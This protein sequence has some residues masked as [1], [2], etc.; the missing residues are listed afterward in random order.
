MKAARRNRVTHPVRR[1]RRV[2]RNFQKVQR[3]LESGA[4]HTLPFTDNAETRKGDLFILDGK[5]MSVAEM[6]ESF[7]SDCGRPDRRL[8][9]VYDNGTENDLLLRSLQ[10]ALNKE[11]A[12]RRITEP[13]L[14]PLFSGE[15]ESDDLPTGR[16]YVL[17]SKSDNP[18]VA[19]NRTVIHKIGVT[20]GDVKRGWPMRKRS[21]LRIGG[22]RD[23]DH[24]QD[25]Q[26]QSQGARGP[27]A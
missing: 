1:H 25:G 11:K 21:D 15:E 27:V 7:V 19:Q 13:G 2:Q 9:L 8:R 17:R 3:E 24:V 18:F 26:H 16:V 22:G 5:K 14:D 6:G 12:S 10:R 20:G 23:R 4:R